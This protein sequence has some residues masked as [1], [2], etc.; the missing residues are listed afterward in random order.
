MCLIFWCIFIPVIFVNTCSQW[1]HSYLFSSTL[2]DWW[3]NQHSFLE[4]IH[5]PSMKYLHFFFISLWSF[6]LWFIKYHFE[7]K[8]FPQ[9]WQRNVSPNILSFTISLAT[10]CLRSRCFFRTG[11]FSPWKSQSPQFHCPSL[12]LF[13]PWTFILWFVKLADSSAASRPLWVK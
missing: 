1:R 9:L 13:I 7:L 3:L 2:P 8:H 10:W 12:D 6:F 5:F 4:N 11:P